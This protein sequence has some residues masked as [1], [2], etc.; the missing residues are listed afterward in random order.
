MRIRCPFCGDVLESEHR[1][2]LKAC[3]CF[4]RSRTVC[5]DAPSEKFVA[6]FGVFEAIEGFRCSAC[7]SDYP[8]F[9][10]CA[11]DGGSAYTRIIGSHWTEV[12][13]E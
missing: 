4:S 5:C 1:H 11:I 9:R 13:D 3:G 12:H 10:G 8:Q 6:G 7:G 2:D